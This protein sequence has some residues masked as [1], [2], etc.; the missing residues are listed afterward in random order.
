MHAYSESTGLEHHSRA[1]WGPLQAWL[2]QMG[3]QALAAKQEEA[4]L[5]FYREGITFAVHGDVGGTER[6][7]PFDILPRILTHDEWDW[8]QR[9]LEQ[10]VLALNLFLADLYGAQHILRDGLVPESALLGNSQYRAGMR[11]V[12]VPRG[13]FAAISGID[14]VRTGEREFH[15]LEDNLRVPSGVSYMLENRRILSWLAPDLFQRCHVEPIGHYP[16]LLAQTLRE[17][18]P[19]HA[20]EPAVVVLT[21]G[22]FNSAYF[23]HAFLAQSI[24]AELVEGQDLLVDDGFLYMKTIHGPQR[25]DVIYRRIDDDFL[26]PRAFRA[27]SMLGVPGLFDV[28]RAGN[29]S[30]A[31][32]PGT[33]VADDKSVYPYVPAMVRYYLD[34]DPILPNVPTHVLSDP[35]QCEWVLAHLSDLVVKEAQGAG[36]YGMLIGPKA[37]RVELEAFAARIRARPDKY[38]AQPTLALST[39]P[40]L[41]DEGVAPRHVDLRPYVLQGASV[42][43][44]PGGLTRVALQAGSLVVNSSQGGGT[45]DTW[46]LRD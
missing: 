46:V 9:G 40:T 23:E 34:Q 3:P 12:K 7:I 28:V 17:L 1:A 35:A 33:G 42:R 13:V 4:R 8:L 6:A 36:G 31:N 15:V 24:G 21:P 5:A 19:G 2:D 32:A 44:V 18:A 22:P 20:D 29:V 16:E 45:K 39:C 27:D 14:L 43:M 26:D 38:I 10:R 25:V 30:L 37:S 41:V 11:G